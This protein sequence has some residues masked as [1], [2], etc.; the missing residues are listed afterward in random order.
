MC[1]SIKATFV[2]AST[3][4]VSSIAVFGMSRNTP[5]EQTAT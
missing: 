5:P 3:L 2:L 1:L 4:I